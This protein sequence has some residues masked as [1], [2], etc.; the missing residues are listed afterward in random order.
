MSVLFTGVEVASHALRLDLEAV[1]NGC[2]KFEGILVRLVLA[3]CF[4]SVA[5]LLCESLVLL[6]KSFELCLL[7]GSVLVLQHASH[8]C[9]GGGL[10]SI[11][12]I[13]LLV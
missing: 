13:L 7:T 12:S 4:L 6:L 10:L 1:I 2:C 5:L 9:N 11:V 3:P 8:S